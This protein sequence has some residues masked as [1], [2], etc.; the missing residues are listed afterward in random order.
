MLQTGLQTETSGNWW[1]DFLA[2]PMLDSFLMDKN[3][4]A[5][6]L[7]VRL[8]GSAYTKDPHG[9]GGSRYTDV[10]IFAIGDHEYLVPVDH[11]WSEGVMLG[12]KPRLEEAEKILERP[13]DLRT[14]KPTR[15]VFNMVRSRDISQVVRDS[16]QA[17][18]E[19]RYH[20]APKAGLAPE[21]N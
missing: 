5:E 20:I 16:L 13:I 21:P 12:G 15:L 3:K 10:D 6:L 4:V 8:A 9:P 14:G 2:L 18:A 17:E 11:A 1:L 19:R 7:P